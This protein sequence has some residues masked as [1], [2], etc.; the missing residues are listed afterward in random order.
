MA[1]RLHFDVIDA[2]RPPTL[3][4]RLH[5]AGENLLILGLVWTFNPA[6][7]RTAKL[8]RGRYRMCMSRGVLLEK[9]GGHG[10]K[11]AD[12]AGG[13]R[14]ERNR[15]DAMRQERAATVDGNVEG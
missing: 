4:N 8:A 12:S 9:Y 7:L 6:G 3:A 1:R 15:A 2:T 10:G 13:A 5:Q 11:G 14:Y